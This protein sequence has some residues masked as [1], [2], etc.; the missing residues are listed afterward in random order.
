MTYILSFL[1]QQKS[2]SLSQFTSQ[3]LAFYLFIF[4]PADSLRDLAQLW[5]HQNPLGG[6]D[7]RL[8]TPL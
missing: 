2:L 5:Y 4:Y 3:L 7:A 1:F 6:N 8:M